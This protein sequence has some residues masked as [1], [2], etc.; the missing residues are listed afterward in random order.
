MKLIKN[1]SIKSNLLNYAN[2]NIIIKK[3]CCESFK[4]FVTLIVLIIEFKR[5]LR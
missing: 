2:D 1:I 4:M 5:K 3:N